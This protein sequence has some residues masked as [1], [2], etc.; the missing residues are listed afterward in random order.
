MITLHSLVISSIVFEKL[1]K[2][3]V[4]SPLLFRA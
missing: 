1:L 4:N 2:S 3:V